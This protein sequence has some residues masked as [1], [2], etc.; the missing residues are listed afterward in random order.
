M[1]S[2]RIQTG[3]SKARW[4]FLLTNGARSRPYLHGHDRASEDIEGRSPSLFHPDLFYPHVF[5]PLYGILH[6]RRRNIDNKYPMH[7]VVMLPCNMETGGPEPVFKS[8][9]CFWIA[10]RTYLQTVYF[11]TVRVW[12]MRNYLQLFRL[13]NRISVAIR[14]SRRGLLGRS[15]IW[16]RR[17]LLGRR[18]I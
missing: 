15:W 1:R 6:H 3:G 5:Q 14:N 9:G 12:Q 11:F 10:K 8:I 4:F 16:R 18:R 17:G 2:G 13:R 7:R